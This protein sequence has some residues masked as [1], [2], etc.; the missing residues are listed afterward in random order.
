MPILSS[1]RAYRGDGART[2]WEVN[3][4]GGYIKPEH[5]FV[6]RNDIYTPAVF[7]GESTVVITPPVPNNED[8]TIERRTPNDKPIVDFADGARLTEENLDTIAKQA[9]FVAAEAL[10]RG[11][12]ALATASPRFLTVPA[13]EIAPQIAPRNELKGK[14]L[15]VSADGSKIVG[16]NFN[17][18]DF[19]LETPFI[20]HDGQDLDVFLQS[21]FD[22]VQTEKAKLQQQ[23]DDAIVLADDV[24]ANATSTAEITNRLNTLVTDFDSLSNI[25]DA[26]TALEGST[27]GLATLVANETAQ[28]IAGDTAMAASINLIGA[29]NGAN[30]A[31]IL[32]LNSVKV[33]PTESLAQR[34]SALKSETDNSLALLQQEQTTRAADDLAEVT[35]RTQMGVQIRNDLG[36][37]LNAA[38]T[39]LTNARVAGDAAEATARQTLAATLRGETDNKITAAVDVEKTARINGDNAEATAR[40]NLAAALRTETDTKIGAAVS[41]EATARANAIAAEATARQS[42]GASLQTNINQAKS[43]VTALVTAEQSARTAALNAEAN[44]R[45]LLAADVESD[46][47][48]V[49]T[50]LTGL[51][52]NEATVRVNA[53]TAEAAARNALATRVGN[54]ESA[55][56]TEQNT[57]ASALSAEA[58]ARGALTT[59]V[60]NTETAITTEQTTRSNAIAAEASARGALAVRVGAAET[61]ITNE[62]SAR[63]T[64]ISAETTARNALTAR[65]TSA[66]GAITNEATVRANADTAITNTVT[67]LTART[68]TAEAA[69]ANESTVRANAITA[70]ANARSALAARVGS[71]ESSITTQA[72][73]LAT[74]LGRTSAFWEVTAVA[75]G[76]AK[77]RVYAD[78]NSGGGVDIEGDVRISGNLLVGGSVNSA[79]LAANAATAGSSG[80]V[81]TGVNLTSTWQTVAECTVP[82]TG[83]A[84]KVDF[85][86]LINGK[87]QG[88]GSN[89]RVRLLRGGTLVRESILCN[90]P[91]ENTQYAGDFGEFAVTT[92]YPISGS[93]P[94]FLVDTAGATGNVTY[95]IQL[96]A[97]A[98]NTQYASAAHR[99]IAVTEFRR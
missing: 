8:F 57:R 32:D 38:V 60:A 14:A 68:T 75:G 27:E 77:L 70:E 16:I 46:I 85:C 34:L 37:N 93:F 4:D 80:Y 92:T 20:L 94:M 63:A 47:A 25:V 1:I 73:V 64:A 61:A 81:E 89:I 48:G 83:G 23:I 65:V 35:A 24:V 15:A 67:A 21:L 56:V 13:N 18:T 84:A 42:L 31:F 28:R 41:N 59:R 76:R 96:M 82:M 52:S 79:Q 62:A 43:D 33:S 44:A 7:A 49:V 9:L 71:T 3:F 54:T 22:L 12:G 98:I 40:T 19:E 78:A 29:K 90:L 6:K 95:T 99:Q 91:G 58:T 74:V 66:E 72:G 88:S 2:Q 55:I 5:V 45:G 10:D 11:E 53:I 69:I 51:I 86:A 36:N 50:S 39:S 87:S 26:L 97:D 17:G 30:N